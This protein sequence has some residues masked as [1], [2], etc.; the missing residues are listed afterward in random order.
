MKYPLEI[1]PAVFAI[2][3]WTSPKG[4]S[5]LKPEIRIHM[6]R[7]VY[8]LM[9]LFNDAFS[10]PLISFQALIVLLISIGCTLTMIQGLSPLTIAFCLLSFALFIFENILLFIAE[11]IFEY[12]RESID[13]LKFGE[14]CRDLAL[15]RTVSSL[16]ECRIHVGSQ[17]FVDR[18][19]L[20]KTND[21]V[22]Q[23]VIS[24]VMLF[25]GLSS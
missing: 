5:S 20:A 23:N 13:K 3:N 6:H 14:R 25:H 19:V 22:V 15:R 7:S 1:L 10:L 24:N 12:S 17:Y 21:M 16:R 11:L 9:G 4:Q 18:G 8:I 2:L